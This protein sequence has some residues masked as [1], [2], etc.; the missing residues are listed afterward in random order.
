MLTQAAVL[1]KMSQALHP[2]REVIPRPSDVA[3]LL[4]FHSITYKT[5]NSS[6]NHLET[7]SVDVHEVWQLSDLTG[8]MYSENGLVYF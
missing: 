7:F 3:T 4:S 5:G 2:Q 8:V 1:Q 6:L